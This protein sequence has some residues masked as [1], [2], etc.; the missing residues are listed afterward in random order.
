MVQSRFS[1]IVQS[2]KPLVLLYLQDFESWFVEVA[3][4]ISFGLV[5]LG[6]NTI[7][8]SVFTTIITGYISI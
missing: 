3:F 7:A 8:N 1:K 4:S 5:C 2:C 6:L